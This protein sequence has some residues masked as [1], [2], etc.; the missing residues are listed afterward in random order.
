[1]EAAAR[2]SSALLEARG[3]GRRIG[4]GWIWR[5]LDLDVRA[6]EQLA[7][8]GPTGSGKTLLL[9]S[10]SALDGIDEGRLF[11][12]GRALDDW[13]P[14]EYRARVTYVRQRPALWEGTV[15]TNLEDVFR[16]AAQHSRSYR[17]DRAID[18]LAAFDRTERFLAKPTAELSGGEQQIT[19]LVRALGLQP[20]VLLLDEPSASMDVTATMQAESL[21]ARWIGE[22]PGRAAIWT[23]HNARQVERVADRTFELD[24]E[25]AT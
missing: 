7:V 9:R 2:I 13:Y 20:S 14:P 16:L 15:E 18:W 17:R 6:G 12:D 1:M 8:V 3:I 10:L 21:V 4:D 24:S 5:E 23:S 22:A 19:A 11:C 25:G